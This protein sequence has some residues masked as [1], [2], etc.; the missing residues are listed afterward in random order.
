MAYRLIYFTL[1]DD[2]Q[3]MFLSQEDKKRKDENEYVDV[4]G[5]VLCVT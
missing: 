5:L 3:A 2:R 1:E 4:F